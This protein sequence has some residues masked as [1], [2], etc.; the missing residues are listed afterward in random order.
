MTIKKNIIFISILFFILTGCNKKWKKTADINLGF[1]ITSTNSSV[2][3]ISII[4][5][6]LK[7]E[8]FTFSGV[9]E[10]GASVDFEDNFTEE[11]SVD[12]ISSTLSQD[13]LYKIPQGKYT[14]IDAIIS[15]NSSDS[16]IIE[17]RG[18]FLDSIGEYEDFIFNLNDATEIDLSNQDLIEIIADQ[19]GNF[20][21]HLDV[22]NWFSSIPDAVMEEANTVSIDGSDVILINKTNNELIYALIVSRIGQNASIKY[23]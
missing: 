2:E 8:K 17:I 3:S 6:T 4:S 15:L 12:C 11:E 19:N 7:L 21:I 14:S 18:Q 5:G 16:A 23:N 9:R 1:A 22:A 20:L 10:K 13:I